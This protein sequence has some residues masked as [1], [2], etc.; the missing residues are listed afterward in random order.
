MD[1]KGHEVRNNKL[2]SI[3]K[4]DKA[5]HDKQAAYSMKFP[6]PRTLLKNEYPDMEVDQLEIF[7]KL[8]LELVYPEPGSKRYRFLD[9][10]Y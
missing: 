10:N 6:R 8:V 2:E 1:K 4:N 7:R 9:L 3:N 5:V